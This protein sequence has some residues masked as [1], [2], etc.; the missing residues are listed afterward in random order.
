MSMISD[1]LALLSTL[2]DKINNSVEVGDALQN[3]AIPN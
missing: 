3:S 1:S 2:I